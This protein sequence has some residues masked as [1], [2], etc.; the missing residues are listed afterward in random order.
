MKNKWKTL[1]DRIVMIQIAIVLAILTLVTCKCSAAN[2]M[3]PAPEPNDV[4]FA[5][6]PNLCPSPVFDWV[7]TSPGTSL[8]YEFAVITRTSLDVNDVNIPALRTQQGDQYTWQVFEK[9]QGPDY[10]VQR[11]GLFWTPFDSQVH[12]LNIIVT[13]ANGASDARTLLVMVQADDIPRIYPPDHPLI[14]SVAW[15]QQLW[16]RA[17]KEQIFASK[18]TRAWR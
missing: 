11:V 16:Q 9:K 14:T 17:K 2:P 12:Y 7:V 4:P 1:N 15:A 6:D 10:W 8:A 13:I 5:Y 18:P 3:P